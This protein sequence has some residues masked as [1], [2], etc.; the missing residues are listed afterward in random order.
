VIC[1][2]EHFVNNFF[3]SEERVIDREN[4]GSSKKAIVKEQTNIS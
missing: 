4:Q 3:G 2:N 1:S